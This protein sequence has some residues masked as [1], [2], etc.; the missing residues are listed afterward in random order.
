L[1]SWGSGIPYAYEEIKVLGLAALG[2]PASLVRA[3]VIAQ[4]DYAAGGRRKM[5]CSEL[6]ACVYR[7]VR[8]PL[9]VQYWK[10]LNDAG[11]F[12]SDDRRLDYTTPNMIARSY[13]LM[14]VGRYLGP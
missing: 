12:V 8:L 13:N 6:V 10:A 1:L 7:D 9:N 4:V 11:I 14:R 3:Y 5:I 2:T